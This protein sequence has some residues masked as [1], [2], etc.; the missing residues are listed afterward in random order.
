[1]RLFQDLF[2]HNLLPDR[3]LAFWGLQDWSGLT[4]GEGQSKHHLAILAVRYFEDQVKKRYAGLVSRLTK[5]SSDTVENFKHVCMAY[6]A[7]SRVPLGCTRSAAEEP[8]SLPSLIRT[9]SRASLS[10]RPSCSARW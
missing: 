2:I 4:A 10:R 6:T 8:L 7:V 5:G 3:K 1:M 9:C